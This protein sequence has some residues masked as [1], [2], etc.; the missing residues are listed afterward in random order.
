MDPLSA[1]AVVLRLV[2]IA[3]RTTSALMVFVHDSNKSSA[4]RTLAE[5]TLSLSMLLERLRNCAKTTGVNGKWLENRT[6]LLR[7]FQKHLTIS[8]RSRKQTPV[9]GNWSKRAVS[10]PSAQQRNGRSPIQK[11]TPPSSMLPAYSSMPILSCLMTKSESL[12]FR[13]H[14]TLSSRDSNIILSLVSC[15]N[16]GI[17]SSPC[18]M[19]LEQNG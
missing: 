4:D 10:D 18:S 7:L 12:F 19:L 15:F 17:I 6:D 13:H 9:Q 1:A 16:W 2:D 3:W 11:S 5:E 14:F 8:L